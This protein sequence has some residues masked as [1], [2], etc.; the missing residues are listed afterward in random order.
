MKKIEDY[1]I[2][3]YNYI[4]SSVGNAHFSGLNFHEL[5]SC[6]DVSSTREELDA[7]VSATIYLK[8]L[9]NKN[10]IRK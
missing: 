8:E 10:D 3:D 2:S 6:I 9:I 7:A 5:W 4:L 1:E